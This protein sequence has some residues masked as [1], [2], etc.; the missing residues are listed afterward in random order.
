MKQITALFIVLSLSFYLCACTA[1][2]PEDSSGEPSQGPTWQEQ[3]DLGVRYL[4]E[5][6]YREAIIA[7]T[8]AIE[9]DPKLAPAYVGRGDAHSGVAR[10]AAGD[11]AELPG[12]AV[13]SYESAVADYLAAIDLDGATAEVYLKAA[14]VYVTLGDVDAALEILSRGIEATGDQS[15]QDYLD[16]LSKEDG[17][18]YLLIRQNGY[19]PDGSLV[20]TWI[21]TYDEQGY[22]LT[23][24][25]SWHTWISSITRVYTWNYDGTPGHCWYIPDRQDFENEEDWLAAQEERIMRPGETGGPWISYWISSNHSIL[26]NPLINTDLRAAVLANGGVLTNEDTDHREWTYAYAVYTFD[27]AG[28]PINIVTYND[29]GAVTGTATLEWRLLDTATE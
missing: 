19:E 28:N 8:A 13:A 29:A 15:L 23:R 21:Y 4:S 7:F 25:V 9:I 6:N 24:E 17:P 12:E 20:G 11:T 5:G 1:A 27:E 18:I 10:L 2:Q 14:E 16:E 3:Y 22:I 26:T